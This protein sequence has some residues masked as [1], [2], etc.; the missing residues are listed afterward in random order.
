M[1]VIVWADVLARYDELSKLP[2]VSSASIQENLMQMAEAGISGRLGGSFTT[3]FSSNNLTAKDLIVDMLY[4]QVNMTRQPEKAKALLDTVDSR[5]AALLSGSSVMLT[6]SGTV[7]LTSVGD[8]VW[9][10]TED[11]PLTFGVSPIEH[12]QVSSQQL[13]DEAVARGELP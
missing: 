12:A 3:P 2:N 5:I 7:A 6:T 9:S 8:T 1:T 13:Y 11:Y 4:V 10:S